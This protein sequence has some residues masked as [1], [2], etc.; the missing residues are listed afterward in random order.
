MSERSVVTVLKVDLSGSTKLG[1][2]LDPEE[3][4][5]VL[6][7]YFTALAREIHRNGGTVDK[8]VGDGLFA[9]FGLPE[10]R[11]DDA[12]RAVFAAIAM[13]E[14]IARENIELRS[15]YGLELAC[16]IG[17]ATGDVV[18]GAVP[19]DIQ[20]GDT[21]VGRPISLAEALESAA[22][23]GGILASPSTREVSRRAIRYAERESVLPKEA[24]AAVDAFRVIGVKRAAAERAARSTGN[25]A[26]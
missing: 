6:G 7:V 4:R 22:P 19:G 20:A 23:L 2:R 1:E 18:V 12:T 17:V 11:P 24:T 25:A 21:F 15:R 26:R 9:V 3:L 8:F 5:A 13:Q 14:A 16:R 10:R